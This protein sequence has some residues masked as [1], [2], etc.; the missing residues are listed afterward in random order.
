MTDVSAAGSASRTEA[1]DL[2]PAGSPTPA[3]SLTPAGSPTPPG[4][5]VW[6]L[7]AYLAALAVVAGVL[8]AMSS[9]A[10]SGLIAVVGFGLVAAMGVVTFRRFVRSVRS[11]Q[12]RQRQS[13]FAAELDALDRLREAGQIREDLIASVSHEFRTPLTAILGNA[14]TLVRR[15]DQLSRD[16]KEGLLIGIL[17]HSDRLNRLLEDMLVA[18]SAAAGDPSGIA[19]VTSAVTALEVGQPRPAVLVD[20]DPRLAA[21]IAPEALRRVVVALGQHLRDTAHRDCPVR[22]EARRFEGSVT[23][24]VDYVATDGGRDLRSLL[25]PFGGDHE[26]VSAGRPVSLALYVVRRL[27]EAHNG[28]VAVEQHGAD[29]RVDVVLRGLGQRSA[30]APRPR[31]AG[32]LVP[33]PAQPR[34]PSSASGAGR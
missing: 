17:E 24:S 14:A 19:D 9:G 20:S 4:S 29:H 16:A 3:G 28:S 22:V 33:R 2:T 25:D 13:L 6:L 26:S 34:V 32:P 5:D 7:T 23:I 8:G 15:Y 27:V 11:E 31:G 10:T 21:L 12:E 30:A 1:G 18:A